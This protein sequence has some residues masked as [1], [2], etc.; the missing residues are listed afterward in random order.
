MFVFQSLTLAEIIWYKYLVQPFSSMIFSAFQSFFH[1]I[2][3]NI[4]LK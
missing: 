4:E 1:I 3:K 2:V